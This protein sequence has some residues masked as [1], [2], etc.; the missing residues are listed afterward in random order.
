M[1]TVRD[2]LDRTDA[3]LEPYA[4]WAGTAVRIGL[5]VSFL[6]GGGYKILEPAV[7][8]AYFAPLFMDLWPAALISLDLV[9][10]L[11]GLF[12]VAFGVLILA[13]WHTPT[14]AGLAVP[15][16]V[17]TNSNFIVAIAQGEPTVDLLALYVALMMMA[18][19]VSLEAASRRGRSGATDES[20]SG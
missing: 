10:L 20:A 12:E 3:L 5:G 13:D 15:W 6:I 18:A 8:Q 4:E 19:G 1:S 2:L 7:Y 14:V 17:G 16:L 9:F 11:A